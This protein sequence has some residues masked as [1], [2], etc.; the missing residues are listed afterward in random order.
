ILSLPKRVAPYHLAV[1]PLLTREPLVVKAREVYSRLLN[2]RFDVYYDE[3]GSIG[4]RYARADEIGI[5]LALTVDY[6]TLEDDTATLRDR[7]TWDQLRIP[8]NG[9]SEILLSYYRDNS[10][11]FRGLEKVGGGSSINGIPHGDRGYC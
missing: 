5:P 4:R 2:G 11:D 7:D 8:L 6:Q 10:M 9:L 3:K 1:F